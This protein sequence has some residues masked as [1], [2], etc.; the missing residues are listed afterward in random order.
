MYCEHAW[1]HADEEL[2]LKDVINDALATQFIQ[3][4]HMSHSNH[5]VFLKDNHACIL[6]CQPFSLTKLFQYQCHPKLRWA[7]EQRWPSVCEVLAQ[8]EG[9]IRIP[10]ASGWVCTYLM[11]RRFWSY[12][13]IH[14][15]C[16]ILGAAAG[17]SRLLTDS[18]FRS[19]NSITAMHSI[20][21]P[22]CKHVLPAASLDTFGKQLT[23]IEAIIVGLRRLIKKVNHAGWKGGFHFKDVAYSSDQNLCPISSNLILARIIYICEMVFRLQLMPC[24]SRYL[25][26]MQHFGE[27]GTGRS[28]RAAY[29]KCCR[30]A[31]VLRACYLLSHWLYKLVS[32]DFSWYIHE[33]F[34][35]QYTCLSPLPCTKDGCPWSFSSWCAA[36][37]GKSTKGTKV[38]FWFQTSSR[39]IARV[40]VLRH[41]MHSCSRLKKV[42]C[43]CDQLHDLLQILVLIVL[44]TLW[45]ERLNLSQDG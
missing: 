4:D 13:S 35:A 9:L 17:C 24:F 1:D 43:T 22:L 19:K 34:W 3:Q 8:I 20:V 16:S 33:E 21:S 36:S 29:P 26:A 14:D 32:L 41:V 6:L 30:H 42:K 44:L 27:T 2:Q 25:H 11:C 15:G 31:S 40:G 5:M 37:T 12:Y 7:A 38:W 28:D 39:S 18:D 10:A 23:T 45:N